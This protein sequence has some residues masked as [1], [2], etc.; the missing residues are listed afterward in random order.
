MCDIAEPFASFQADEAVEGEEGWLYLTRRHKGLAVNACAHALFFCRLLQALRPNGTKEALPTS[1]VGSR[2]LKVGIIGGGHLGKQLARV[3][4]ALGRA[5]RPSIR[6]STR[7]PESLADLQ[8]Q[9]L[10]C[11]YDNAQ[12]AAWA[13]VLFLCCLPSHLAAV[14]SAVRTA[15]RKPCVV[16]SL[17]TAVPLPRLK[18]LLCY[19]AI[20]RP[21][22]QC[23]GQEPTKEW[24]MKGT[25]TAALQDLAVV[26]ATCPLS[27]Q[28]KIRVNGK[29]LV[30]I[31]YAALNSSMWQNLPHQKALKLL[32]DLCFP[33]RCPICAEQKA[34]CPRFERK[35]FVS[36]NFASSMTQEETFPWFDLTAAQLRE[37][38]FSQLLDKSEFLQKHLALLYQASFGDWPTKQRGLISTKTS[39]TSAVV[40][41]GM[42]L[43]HKTSLPTAASNIVS[44]IPEETADYDSK[45]S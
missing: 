16:Y 40:E 34:S 32:N 44:E 14:C 38:P 3:L 35:S 6:I 28:G 12:L 8:E 9:G 21:Q 4:L 1:L 22:Y 18:Q 33:A 43:A 15:I 19:N 37:S 25:V 2:G 20:V 11:L 13:D 27:S 24:E 5:P 17:V 26:Q 23:P 31:F 10:T 41:P 30:G 36:K 29:W 45:S 39:L 7:R 42:V